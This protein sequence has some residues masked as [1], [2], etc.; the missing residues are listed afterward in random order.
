MRDKERLSRTLD[1]VDFVVHARFKNFGTWYVIS[2]ND[3]CSKHGNEFLFQMQ[4]IGNIE[5][6]NSYNIKKI[7]TR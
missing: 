6:M 2:R 3:R 1:G 5:I 7:V 4:A